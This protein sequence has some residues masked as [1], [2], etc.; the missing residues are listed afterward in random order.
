MIPTAVAGY[1][2]CK[3][4]T[5]QKKEALTRNAPEVV[6]MREMS[7]EELGIDHPDFFF[8]I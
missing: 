3:R 8:E 6:A 1:V 7:F 2:Y 4:R 5:Q